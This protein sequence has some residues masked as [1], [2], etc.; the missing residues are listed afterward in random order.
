MTW[1]SFFD[2]STMPHRHL[3]FAYVAVWVIQGGYFAW[4]VW[5]WV[6]ARDG[7]R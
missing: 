1:R 3:L 2:L 5:N 7:R 4:T 6:H